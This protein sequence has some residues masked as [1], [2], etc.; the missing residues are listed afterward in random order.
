M[1]D[2]RSPL[3]AQREAIRHLTRAPEPDCVAAL[4]PDATWPTDWQATTRGLALALSA[5]LR[6]RPQAHGRE[7]LVQSLM[8]EFALSSQEGIA[9]MCLAEA[10]LR[11]PD[12]ATRDALIRD[13]VADGNWAAHLGQSPSMFVN[14]ATWGLVLTGRLVGLHAE[15]GLSAA[16]RRV[17]IKG[18]EQLIRKGVDIAMRLLGETFVMGES[19]QAALR[20]AR[21]REAQGFLHSYDML[22]EAALTGPTP[23]ATPRPTSTPSKP[24][25]RWPRASLPACTNGPASR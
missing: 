7:G 3:M 9:L 17:A 22:G 1:N 2:T 21:D 12:E 10:L 20:K 18:G 19:I 23:S 8:Q 16:L 5:Q 6:E 24:L 25:A 13:K 14:A 11:I 15:S 4:L